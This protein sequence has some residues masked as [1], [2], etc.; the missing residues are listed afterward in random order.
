[1]KKLLFIALIIFAS[2]CSSSDDSEDLILPKT[3]EEIR[4]EVSDS[5][6]NYYGINVNNLREVEVMFEIENGNKFMSGKSSNEIWIG[7]FSS[8]NE[9][10]L[11]ETFDA[12][13]VGLNDY[14]IY[15]WHNGNIGG[16]SFI[17]LKLAPKENDI[18]NDPL[19]GDYLHWY[20]LRLNLKDNTLKHFYKKI[21]PDQELT[22][23]SEISISSGF[24]ESYIL[25][26]NEVTDLIYLNSEFENPET[27]ENSVDCFPGFPNYS[28][29]DN[30]I[31]TSKKTYFV[32]NQDERFI[33][34]S[35]M[36][37]SCN[38]WSL[39]TLKDF[40]N[41][42]LSC[43]PNVKLISYDENEI[44]FEYTNIDDQIVEATVDVKTGEVISITP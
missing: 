4:K 8:S 1:M 14:F 9:T 36:T 3:E 11:S 31:F 40:P 42:C 2:S 39:D 12:G 44:L 28:E 7:A 25:K 10:L 38:E 27:W 15:G 13:S 35:D 19:T 5:L 33:W 16:N 41:V 23:G 26:F 24:E 29:E 6:I 32:F 34:G 20:V 30:L 22:R 18:T 17:S 43:D 21:A 37:N